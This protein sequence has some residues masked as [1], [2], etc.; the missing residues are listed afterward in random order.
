MTHHCTFSTSH[1]RRVALRT[2]VS[3]RV[4]SSAALSIAAALTLSA[5]GGSSNS[6]DDTASISLQNCGRTVT[7]NGP[8]E[9]GVTLNQGATE[10]ALS[11][12]AQDRM[13]GTAYLDDAVA[14]Q[15]Q[16][17]YAQVPALDEKAYPSRE[18]LLETKPDLVLASYSSAFG[19]KGV[20]AQESFDELGIATYVSPF[21]CKDKSKRPPVAWDSIA[22]EITDYGTLFGHEA[23]AQ[24]EVARMRETLAGVEAAAPAKGKTVFW[25]DSKTTTPYVGG[26]AGGPQ[27]IIDA[28]GG[29]NI[30]TDINGA[31]ADGSWETVLKANPDVIV[32]ADA[33]WDTAEAKKEYLRGDPALKDLKAVRDNAFVV[34]PFSATTPGPRLIEG[35][36][37]VSEQL[38]GGKA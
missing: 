20:G 24:S 7:L 17:A 3:R 15:W 2:P 22:T 5:C 12:G 21:G 9:R 13:V 10:S 25:Y 38:G 23:E 37:L 1:G 6:D 30:F 19:D 36:T 28:V 4:I 31:W 35:A 18:A 11:I 26:N 29:T 8:A 16:A 14:P 27:L 34:V 32:L 33:S